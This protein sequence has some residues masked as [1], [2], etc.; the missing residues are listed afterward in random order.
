MDQRTLAQIFGG[1]GCKIYGLNKI[2][3]IWPNLFWLV[4]HVGLARV[5]PFDPNFLFNFFK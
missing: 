1:L 2:G 4:A 5:S 3:Q